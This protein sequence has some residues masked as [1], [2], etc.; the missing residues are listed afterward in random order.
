M[1]GGLNNAW[2][3]AL[4]V[5]NGA[6]RTTGVGKNLAKGELAL[7]DVNKR[8]K[9]GDLTGAKV[10]SSTAGYDKKK[11]HFQLR[12]GSAARQATRSQSPKPMGTQPFA[13]SEVV[14]L[15]VSAPD[16]DVQKVDEIILGYDGINPETAFSFKSGDSYFNLWLELCG[17]GISY[18]GSGVNKEIFEVAVHLP[19]CDATDACTDCDDCA[20]VDCKV[21]TNELIRR[22]KEKQLS[23]GTSIEEYVEITPVFSCDTDASRDLIAY[24][25]Y[26][27]KVCDTGTE[28]DLSKIQ[29]Q[30][31]NYKVV[32]KDRK[33]PNSTYEILV[34]AADGAPANYS[35][36]IESILKG[37]EDCPAG[38]TATDSGVLYA[39]TIED[40][41]ADLT[42]NFEALPGFVADTVIKQGN[43]NGVGFY[44]FLL[45]NA[46]TDAE[47]TAFLQANDVQ[48]T[49]RFSLQGDVQAICTNGTTSTTA[50][51]SAGTCNISTDRYTITLADD[52]CDQSRLAELQAAYPEYLIA[53]G[54]GTATIAVTLTG[55]SGTANIN[56]GGVDYLATFGD[57]LADTADDFLASHDTALTTAGFTT[58]VDAGVITF[59][60]DID[61][62][63]AVTITN[64]TGDL[65]GTLGEVTGV[66]VTGGCQR[67]YVATVYTNMVCDECDPIFKD[68]YSSEVP[69]LWDNR[70]WEKVEVAGA[71][72]SGNC[73]CGI[74]IKAKPFIL[75]SEEALRH[76]V[77]FVETSSS[78]RAA[79]GYPREQRLGIGNIPNASEVYEAVY[80]SHKA[81]RTHLAGNLRD[82]ENEGNVYF[83][84]ENYEKDYLSRVLK[85]Q[86][87]N[88][89]DSRAQIVQYQLEIAHNNY[90]QGFAGKSNDNTIYVVQ[91]ELGKHQATENLL[92]AIAAGAG[93][94]GVKAFG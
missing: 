8:A 20:A 53:E 49:A 60:G 39:A 14:S 81:D 48:S 19:E 18:N 67:K 69:T 76:K 26:Q 44:T 92:N 56:V 57:D 62:I 36:G 42:S 80:L 30:Y 72:P 63:R 35:V 38:Y 73:L 50:W 12:L 59:E 17:G 71:E 64:A 11:K 91:V 68:Q 61:D 23:G 54:E 51:T 52:D 47:L 84:G 55:T 40:D 9:V 22:L 43:D 75:D 37:C 33:G 6:V 21:V 5:A 82:F 1:S 10:I 25:F 88:F 79:A 28:A 93:I 15:S 90:T 83:T 70:R 31:P 77:Q 7:V 85:G 41:G 16:T 29:A 94:E 46:L 4:S 74:R 34:P 3:R 27:I 13:L 32:A 89:P 24:N 86:V 87:T 65:A 2:H 66:A 58:A 78:I 45:D